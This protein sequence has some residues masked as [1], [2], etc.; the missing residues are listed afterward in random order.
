MLVTSTQTRDDACE[1]FRPPAFNPCGFHSF[2]RRSTRTMISPNPRRLRGALVAISLV[3]ACVASF[4]GAKEDIEASM[5]AGQWSQA[6][7]QLTSV[8]DKHPRNALAHYWRA[9]VKAELGQM[10]AAREELQQA[11]RIDPSEKFAG[12]KSVLA[13]LKARL[14]EHGSGPAHTQVPTTLT[15]QGERMTTGTLP[16]RERQAEIVPSQDTNASQGHVGRWIALGISVLVLFGLWSWWN[17]RRQE[18][19]T[20]ENARRLWASELED[21]KRDLDDAIRWSDG[22]PQ[23]SPEARLANYDRCNAARQEVQNQIAELPRMVNFQGAETAVVR[24]HDIAAEVRGEET[25]SARAERGGYGYPAG[26]NPGMGGMGM[27]GG[28]ATGRGGSLLRDAALLGGGAL[29]GTVLANEARA[30][31]ER[32]DAGAAPAGQDNGGFEPFQDDERIELGGSN[33]GGS[34]DSFDT[35]GGWDVGGSDDTNFD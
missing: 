1:A 35:G 4:A 18:A 11:E 25:P 26:M 15:P 28:M 14:A 19:R 22:Q 34:D 13:A 30:G 29:L 21:A 9:Q 5:R 6:D 20:R 33:A 16:A 7:Q 24:A 27:P 2:V 23:L 12:D 3:V 31:E 8:L 17:G 32:H 10:Q